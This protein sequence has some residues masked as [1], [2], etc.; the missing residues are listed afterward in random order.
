MYAIATRLSY[1]KETMQPTIFSF[2]LKH[3]RREQVLLLLM[4][5]AAFPFLYLSLDLPKTI[6]NEAIGG[7]EFPKPFLGSEFEQ[8]PFLLALCS[9]FLALVLL[10]GA[11]KYVINVYRGAVGERMLRR[12]RYMLF[13]HVLRFPVGQFRKMSQGEIVSMI[14][15]ET[16]PLGGYIG[17]SIA[18]PAFQGGTLLTILVF[19]F[20]QDPILGAAAIALYPI[21]AYV[22]PKFQRRVNALKKERV[23]RVRKLSERI[24]EVVGGIEEL[25]SNATSAYE[26]ADY[27]KRLGEIYLIRFQVYRLKFFIKFLNNFI[28]Q[29]TPFF[30]YSIGGYLVIKGDLSFGALVAVLAAYK[31]LSSP[32][33][34]LL[35]FYQIKEDARIKYDLLYETFQ[36]RGMLPAE[37]L[38]DEIDV[39]PRFD[40]EL[41][42]SNLNL[43]EEEDGEGGFGSSL[44]VAFALP[45]HVSVLGETGSGK[46]RLAS[47]LG[48][49]KKPVNG[50]IRL[51]SVDLVTAPHA[52][53]G[54]Y[55]AYVGSDP[56]L[57]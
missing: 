12:L 37:V 20:V 47:I 11:F 46:S 13:E 5:L 24:G 29:I 30:F 40:Q 32:W 51:D 34:E 8:I 36:P 6:I 45:V 42:I 52:L 33:K 26:L 7:G 35:N 2:I 10:N 15:A 19:M 55:L 9:A 28:A 16:E 56:A 27:S 54:R 53:T 21:Q 1:L 25:H 41:V 44:S 49:V 3:S 18:L 31:D 39:L 38:T 23:V 50:S 48:G 17:D 4:T 57:A 14:T 43:S 22:I